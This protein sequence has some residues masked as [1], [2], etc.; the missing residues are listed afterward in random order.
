V[1]EKMVKRWINLHQPFGEGMPSPKIFGPISMEQVVHKIKSTKEI[2]IRFTR[3]QFATHIGTHIDAAS[4]MFPAGKTIDQYPFEKFVGEGVILE[5][6]RND[7]VPLTAREIKSANP[8]IKKGDIVLLYTGWAEKYFM[9]EAYLTHPYLSE[10][11]ANCLAELGINI[12]GMDTITPDMP[13][14][15]R[16]EGFSFPVHRILL[17]K[18]ILVIENLGLN[19]AKLVGKRLII[20]T[21]PIIIK[22]ADG[23][24]SAVFGLLEE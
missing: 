13:V 16:P 18:D 21:F 14:P 5:M 1:E 22:G 2:E 6:R 23:G 24:P 4:H 3:Y 19:L 20:G 9:G 11:A 7:P 15:L 12:I 17:S 8:Q 10:D